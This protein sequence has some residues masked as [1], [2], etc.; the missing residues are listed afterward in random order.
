MAG[1]AALLRKDDEALA[2]REEEVATAE[3]ERDRQAKCCDQVSARKEAADSVLAIEK[4]KTGERKAAAKT[5]HRFN[6]LVP[7]VRQLAEGARE[8]DESTAAVTRLKRERGQLQLK[9]GALEKSV[10]KAREEL[11]TVSDLASKS[12]GCKAKL[13]IAE[14]Q[15]RQRSE[16]EDKRDGLAEARNE[17]TD[18]KMRLDDASGKLRSAKDELG[19]VGSDAKTNQQQLASA[20]TETAKLSGLESKLEK[21]S[22]QLERRE[23]LADLQKELKAAKKSAEEAGTAIEAEEEKLRRLRAE[24]DSV[25]SSLRE[26]QAGVLAGHLVDGEACP[27]CGS[28]DHPSPARAVKNLPSQKQLKSFSATIE[29]QE[30]SVKAAISEQQR[31]LETV[32]GIKAELKSVRKEL[33]KLKEMTVTKLKSACETAETRLEKA[34]SSRRRVELLEGRRD[35]LA[36]SDER[37]HRRVEKLEEELEKARESKQAADRAVGKLESVV[38]ALQKEL[39]KLKAVPLES[40]EENLRKAQEF[41]RDAQLAKESKKESVKALKALEGEHLET[42]SH[43]SNVGEQLTDVTKRQA[44]AAGIAEQLEAE[45]P[46]DLA[47]SDQLRAA[48]AEAEELVRS[49]EKAYEDA[50]N[51]AKEAATEQSAAKA[52]V[53]AAKKS[54]RTA[55]QRAVKQRTKFKTAREAAGFKTRAAYEE[56]CLQRDELSGLRSEIKTYDADLAAGKKRFNAARTHSKSIKKPDLV[57]LS[58][59]VDEAAHATVVVRKRRDDL[60]HDLKQADGWQKDLRSTASRLKKLEKQYETVGLISDVAN[61]KNAAGITFQRFVLGALLDDVLLEASER[62]RTMS[63]GRFI[64]ERA[65]ERSDRRRTGGLD[66]VVFDSHTGTNRPVQSLSG[67]ESF[68]ASLSLAL[69]LADVVQ[70]YSGGIHLETIFIDEGFG[71][72]DAEALDLAIRTLKD[73]QSGGRLVGIISHVS[74]LKEVVDAR[75]EV[76]AGRRGSRA[77]FV[78]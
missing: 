49:L 15:H 2:E 19:K 51:D 43:L 10:A 66:L 69:G 53:A 68:L 16:L 38:E 57:K 41:L 54:L 39:G 61:G 6:A 34:R 71:T 13:K 7:K 29:K 58:A 45:I 50:S 63:K 25:Q 48:I 56:A 67:G 59:A 35:E 72:L 73:L 33:G 78:I 18:C 17:A 11:S 8:L 26:G 40:T 55:K 4:K 21:A 76:M 36:D 77:K 27:V 30:A 31:C 28:L 22:K 14:Q 74:E 65:R 52:D 9:K 24:Y 37:L 75:L 3:A 20:Q 12:S 5:V 42:D 1:K 46:D 62:L 64:L 23:H 32:S 70:A 44:K 60:T 47:S